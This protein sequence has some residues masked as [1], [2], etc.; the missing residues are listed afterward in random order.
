MF[1]RFSVDLRIEIVYLASFF[2]LPSFYLQGVA[3]EFEVEAMP[4]FIFWKEGKVVH[5]IVGADKDGLIKSLND[6][7]GQP[8]VATAWL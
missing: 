3:A 1:F 7:S 4:T 2:K 6:L 5:K 8:A